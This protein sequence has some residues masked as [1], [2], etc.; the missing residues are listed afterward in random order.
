MKGA[1]G[2]H[3][4]GEAEPARLGAGGGFRQDEEFLQVAQA[5][6]QR[7]EIAPARFDEAVQLLQLRHAHRRLHVGELQV[8]ADVRVGVLVVVA[9]GQA[10]ELPVEALAAGVVLA[11]LRTSSRGPSRGSDSTSV[12]SSGWS[13]STLPPSPMV[14][15][16]A[17]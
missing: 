12:C 15:W 1:S 4:D 2:A 17:G 16:C 10:A 14:M 5:L 9:V 3:G 7:C 8:V 13:V 11:G 6:A